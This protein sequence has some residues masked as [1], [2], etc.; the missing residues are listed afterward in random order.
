M[1]FN[2]NASFG[3]QIL[4]IFLFFSF[5]FSLVCCFHYLNRILVI[6]NLES[7]HVMFL[8]NVTVTL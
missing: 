6:W 3:L 7:Y 1:H 5:H 4:I 2:L 8:R